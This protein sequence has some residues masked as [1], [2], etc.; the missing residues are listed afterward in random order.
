MTRVRLFAA[1]TAALTTMFGLGPAFAQN[2]LSVDP[3]RHIAPHD[4]PA[5]VKQLIAR[6]AA[7]RSAGPDAAVDVTP[8][9]ITGFNS[10]TMMNLT[11]PAAPFKVTI[12]ATDDLS[13]ITFCTFHAWGPHDQRMEISAQTGVPLVNFNIVG[14]HAGYVNRL[15]E[16]GT[17]KF[18]FGYCYDAANNYGD[19]DEAGLDALGNAAFT[20]ISSGYDLQKPALTGGKVLTGAVSLSSFAPG[21][22]NEPYVGV[23]LDLADTGETVIAGASDVYANFCLV[24]NPYEC[25]YLTGKMSAPGMSTAG[26]V[27]GTPVSASWGNMPGEYALRSIDVYD[28][29]GNYNHYES[30]LF[31]GTTDFAPLFGGVAPKIKLKP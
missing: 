13:G 19:I 18:K 27:A 31:G 26:V 15:F 3:L 25:L 24:G 1:C 22:T 6:Q 4:R 8:P 10:G 16:P 20:V 29:A 30:T 7:Q 28:Y 9:V 11:K 2:A 21:T 23:R 14:G 12:K 5:Y 17:W